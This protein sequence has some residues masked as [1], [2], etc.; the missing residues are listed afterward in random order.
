MGLSIK[1]FGF[2]LPFE[3]FSISLSRS[4][5][6]INFPFL[7][8]P[9][10]LSILLSLECQIFPTQPNFIVKTQ[11]LELFGILPFHSIVSFLKSFFQLFSHLCF[12]SQQYPPYFYFFH[13][14]QP[15]YH[16]LFLGLSHPN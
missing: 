13:L 16:L 10:N 8:Y 4:P 15:I 1:L 14:F 11:T 3:F 9:L 6:I 5:L 12:G 2:F 7:S